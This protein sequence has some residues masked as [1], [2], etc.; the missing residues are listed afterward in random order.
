M[1]H[2]EKLIM[3]G[4]CVSRKETPLHHGEFEVWVKIEIECVVVN[5]KEDFFYKQHVITVSTI[6]ASHSHFLDGILGL[7]E[8]QNL[9]HF[10]PPYHFYFSLVLLYLVILF[11]VSD[12][13]AQRSYMTVMR[14]LKTCGYCLWFHHCNQSFL[15]VVHLF[16][17]PL[18]LFYFDFPIFSYLLVHYVQRNIYC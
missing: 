11:F 6:L 13:F 4:V 16:V 2:K 12:N 7:C 1:Y 3:K 14:F 9:L 18:F 15:T 17:F 10:P 5:W 8:V